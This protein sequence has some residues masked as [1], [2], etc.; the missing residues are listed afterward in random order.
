MSNSTPHLS[1]IARR[2]TA[3]L[4]AAMML[5][6]ATAQAKPADTVGGAAGQ[7]VVAGLDVRSPDARDAAQPVVTPLDVRSPDARDAAQPTPLVHNLSN[8]DEVALAQERSYSSYGDPKPITAVHTGTPVSS[9]FD[10]PSAGIG[11]GIVM[12]IALLGFTGFALSTGR[13]PGRG[14][15]TS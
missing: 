5:V 14:A 8:A 3:A 13:R 10:W 11:A 9:D 2:F 7:P 1:P 15:L 6:P 12:A 4:A